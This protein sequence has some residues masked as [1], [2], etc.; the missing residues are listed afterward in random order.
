MNFTDAYRASHRFIAKNPTLSSR[1]DLLY[2]WRTR[3][4][5]TR[6]F[7]MH[8]KRVDAIRRRDAPS[9]RCNVW[10]FGREKSSGDGINGTARYTVIEIEWR[11]AR[12]A[13]RAY[14][15]VKLNREARVYLHTLLAIRKNADIQEKITIAS[16]TGASGIKCKSNALVQC[17]DNIS[18]PR[19]F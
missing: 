6:V 4:P 10:L 2:H 18:G 13:F 5:L 16:R 15:K 17:R 11:S 1:Q 12:I 9:T 8:R 19:N 14:R 3:E 7:P